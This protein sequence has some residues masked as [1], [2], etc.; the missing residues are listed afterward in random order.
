MKDHRQSV[1]RGGTS[2][3][4]VLVVI[5]ILSLL[6]ALTLG[7]V[8]RVRA[9]AARAECQSRMRQVG[10]AVQSYHATHRQYPVGV[11]YPF[12]QTEFQISSEHAGISWLTSIL[13]QLEQGAIWQQTW[14]AHRAQPGGTSAAHEA[15]WV[16][17][18]GVFRCPTDGR[19]AGTTPADPATSWGLNNYIGTSGTGLLAD[20]GILLQNRSVSIAAVTD[21]TSNTLLFGERPSNQNG[22]QSSWYAGWGQLRFLGGQLLPVSESWANAPVTG[23]GGCPPVSLFEAGVYDSP[24]HQNHFW[25]LHSGGANFALADG[26]VRFLRYSAVGILPALTTKAGGE[27]VNVLD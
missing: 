18:I 4:E 19:T 21:G 5:A 14:D 10:L 22:V 12:S 17:R 7:G 24:C 23:N 11:A 16:R 8:Q 3:I 15:I 26:S 6:A 2:L 20:D 9:T 1:D 25:S 27:T 13:P